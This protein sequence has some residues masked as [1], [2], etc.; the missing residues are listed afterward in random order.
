MIA[1]SVGVALPKDAVAQALYRWMAF[2]QVQ[3]FLRKEAISVID[4][5]P[6]DPARQLL[7]DHQ[8]G[9]GAEEWIEGAVSRVGAGQDDPGQQLLRLLC[10]MYT[11]GYAA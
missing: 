1:D 11:W 8:G 7:R 5:H 2:G 4:F 6:C 3:P 9:A 10:R